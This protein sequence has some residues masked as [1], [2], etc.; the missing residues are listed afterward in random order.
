MSKRVFI[1]S[2]IYIFSNF[3]ALALTGDFL[4]SPIDKTLIQTQTE[5]KLPH[6]LLTEIT[7][8]DVFYDQDLNY[9]KASGNAE[10]KLAGKDFTLYADLITYDGQ[11]DLIEA[12][13]NV[14]IVDASNEIY[15]SYVAFELNS[16]QYTVDLPQAYL[17]GLKFKS[18]NLKSTYYD[19]A[20]KENKNKHN[21][22]IFKDGLIAL[23]K[24]VNLYSYGANIP[25]NYSRD[26]LRYH[27]NRIVDWNN[28]SDKSNFTYSAKEI[29]FDKTR[30]TNNLKIKGAKIKVSDHF[31]ISSPIYITTTIGE[32]AQTKFK[33][34]IIGNRERIG[35]F[36]L[37][38]RFYHEIEQGVFSLIPIVQLGNGPAF[39]A[40]A[41]ASFNTPNDT[42]SLMLGYG[43]L[44][45]RMIASAHQDIIGK[46]FQANALI[47]QFQTDNIF[48]SSQVG[49]L[50]EI[51]SDFRWHFPFLDERGLRLRLSGNWAKDNIDLFSTKRLKD[52]SFERSQDPAREEH[53]GFKAEIQTSFY[54]EPFLRYGN[55]LRNLSLRTRGQG[56]LRAYDT[57]DFLTVGRF[58]PALEARIE[59][60]AFEI[61][62]LF[63][64][65]SGQ[66]PFLYDQFFDGN[67]S[68]VF[69]GDYKINRW[70]SLGT[71][72]TYNIDRQKIVRNEVRTE[73]GAED[74][75]LRLSYDTILNQINLGFNILF[76][77]PVKFSELKLR[78]Q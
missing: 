28:L 14:K 55:E 49:Q 24:P 50:Y 74:F 70:F 39:G 64:A 69:D 35:G 56:T 58:G 48:G 2:F 54:T 60:F 62:Y 34:P 44:Y 11:K 37:G 9:Y 29:F 12:Q 75:K 33:G 3:S 38:P 21:D 42:S 72:S 26:I 8:D 25:T 13:G 66:S 61:D 57:G 45:N 67:Q 1:A 43:S 59:N 52:L 73:F 20:Q 19:K 16:R 17:D 32:A 46:K 47:N 53:S 18:R 27:E 15:G 10:A 30:K 7:A 68:L 51:A 41:V 76:G 5:E 22:L 71:N 6:N 4:Q 31:T 77:D 65:I 40:G 63:A 78:T 23:D 36:A